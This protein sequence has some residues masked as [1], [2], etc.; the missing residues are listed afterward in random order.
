MALEALDIELAES[1]APSAGT[2]VVASS[3]ITVVEPVEPAG[4]AGSFRAD[5]EESKGQ[6]LDKEYED[7][8]AEMDR[9][10]SNVLRIE[11]E[12]FEFPTRVR[13]AGQGERI[14]SLKSQW[15]SLT[16]KMGTQHQVVRDIKDRR[17]MTGRDLVLHRLQEAMEATEG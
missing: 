1:F 7:A 13:L 14:K 17:R 4:P 6:Q 9:L 12:Y 8:L 11:E 5:V 3:A 10:T 16:D 15:D 2:T